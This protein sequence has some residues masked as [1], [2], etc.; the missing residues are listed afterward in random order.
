M[1]LREGGVRHLIRS[2]SCSSTSGTVWPVEKNTAV[3][4]GE[5]EAVTKIHETALSLQW[6]EASFQHRAYATVRTGYFR[7]EPTLNRF[8]WACRSCG[9][10]CSAC[11]NGEKTYNKHKVEDNSIERDRNI[12]KHIMDAH[13]ARAR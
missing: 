1:F 12:E 13:E 3:V 4:R 2:S 7:R 6:I 5:R 8:D 10:R 9:T 11:C